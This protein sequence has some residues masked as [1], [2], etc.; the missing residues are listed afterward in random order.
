MQSAIASGNSIQP[1]SGLFRKQNPSLPLCGHQRSVEAQKNLSEPDLAGLKIRLGR[2][3]S[4]R[5]C[6]FS[7]DWMRHLTELTVTF[8]DIRN[9]EL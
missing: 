1:T 8:R 4:M 7:G 6:W 9:A 2:T 5:R 3:S